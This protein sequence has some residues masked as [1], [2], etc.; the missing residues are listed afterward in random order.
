MEIP[1]GISRFSPR[2]RR[3]S[4]KTTGRVW[5]GGG[6]RDGRDKGQS[7][8]LP[9]HRPRRGG[10]GRALRP[11]AAAGGVRAPRGVHLRHAGR[12][13]SLPVCATVTARGRRPRAFE[14]TASWG[15]CC[16][17]FCLCHRAWAGG[18]SKA[19]WVDEPPLATRA[20]RPAA[21]AR[22]HGAAPCPS[23][24]PLC[25]P[26][27]GSL[28][29]SVRGWRAGCRLRVPR[30]A[31]TPH[32]LR[33]LLLRPSETVNVT[34]AH[35][36]CHN[37]PRAG[38][39]PRSPPEARAAREGPLSLWPTI[40]HPRPARRGFWPEPG[41]RRSWRLHRLESRLGP[42]PFAPSAVGAVG[43]VGTCV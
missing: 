26:W 12:S 5:G 4:W 29:A 8:V 20:R 40:Q 22:G 38:G 43:G 24:G 35:R 33:L 6:E 11:R 13:G 42:S 34:L 28:A 23:R 10:R 7:Q 17:G 15:S 25:A 36:P 21:A 19:A 41:Q 39:G 32:S 18:M 27:P 3:L 1:R 31:S 30:A 14:V 16:S 37:G 2:R 9:G